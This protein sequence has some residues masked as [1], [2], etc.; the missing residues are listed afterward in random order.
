MNI[1]AFGCI[2]ALIMGV[3][4]F[5]CALLYYKICYREE[6]FCRYMFKKYDLR[7]EKKLE[8][9]YKDMIETDLREHLILLAGDIEQHKVLPFFGT[10]ISVLLGLGTTM[11]LHVINSYSWENVDVKSSD[12]L[13][14]CFF[15]LSIQLVITSHFVNKIVSHNAIQKKVIEYVLECKKH[16][17]LP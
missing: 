7:F 11:L 5:V 3:L 12:L 6:F 1:L 13:F 16:K 9:K 8:I 17:L 15:A 2:V 4:H 14:I 10:V